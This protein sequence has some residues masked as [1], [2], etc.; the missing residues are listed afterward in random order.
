MSFSDILLQD[1]YISFQ[2]SEEMFIVCPTYNIPS[3]LNLNL[4]DNKCSEARISL[5][6]FTQ[7]CLCDL[8]K[9]YLRIFLNPTFVE[10]RIVTE[11]SW[12]TFTHYIQQL[13]PLLDHLC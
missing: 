7:S 4:P 3:L 9:S 10:S 13:Q 12:H 6:M 8:C 5:K 11:N 1:A 2:N